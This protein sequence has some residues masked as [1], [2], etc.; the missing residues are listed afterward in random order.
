MWQVSTWRGEVSG[1]ELFKLYWAYLPTC[2]KKLYFILLWIHLLI[3]LLHHLLFFSCS[4]WQILE[5]S[6]HLH[7]T[8]CCK[9]RP[10]SW[11]QTSRSPP[12]ACLGFPSTVV[13]CKSGLLVG[14][15]YGVSWYIMSAHLMFYLCWIS[16]LWH[17]QNHWG[18]ILRL[19][20]LQDDLC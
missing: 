1:G 15:P 13:G 7:Q 6:I 3:L 17:S 18:S 5:S 2:G 19:E 10:V 8:H 12:H 11:H 20:P 9:A 16:M 14:H 4:N